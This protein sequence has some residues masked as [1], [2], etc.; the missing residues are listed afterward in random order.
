MLLLLAGGVDGARQ[1]ASE[2]VGDHQI[3]V[4]Y[5]RTGVR[6]ERRRLLLLLFGAAIVVHDGDRIAVH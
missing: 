4:H 1:R 5:G 6:I 3:V 2:L